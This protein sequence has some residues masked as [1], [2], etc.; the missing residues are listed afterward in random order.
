MPNE[1]LAVY[2]ADLRRFTLRGYPDADE[3]TRDRIA[4]RQFIRGLPDQ[5]LALAVGLKDPANLGEAMDIV[6][7]YRSLHEEHRPSSRT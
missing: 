4:L 7:R 6:E 3:K 1:S 5:Q 2:A